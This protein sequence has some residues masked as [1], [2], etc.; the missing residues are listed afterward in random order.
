MTS[1]IDLTSADVGLSAAEARE[2]RDGKIGLLFGIAALTFLSSLL[3]WIIQKRVKNAI[4]I[5]TIGICLAAG[6]ILGS[7]LSHQI[8]EAQV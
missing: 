7:A 1:T 8:P 3:P 6:I 4:T 5:M 2:I